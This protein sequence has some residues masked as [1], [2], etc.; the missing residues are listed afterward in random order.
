MPLNF[1]H[2]GF[3]SMLFPDAHVIHC[4][5]DPLDTCLSCYIH[6]LP[7]VAYAFTYNLEH[8]GVY[9]KQY[10]RLM[11]HWMTAL[12]L[13]IMEVRYEELVSNQEEI[14]RAMIG[15]SG[16]EWDDRCLRFN[17]N[18]R[19][20][21][22]AS[23]QQVRKPMFSTSIGRWKYYGSYLTPLKKVLLEE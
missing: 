3:I 5:R 21:H 8:L 15:F 19:L 16:L 7:E 11:N 14:S 17:E 20:V 2:L 9:Y 22:T 10:R 18:E 13:R 12:L 4:V 23:I 1:L 6:E